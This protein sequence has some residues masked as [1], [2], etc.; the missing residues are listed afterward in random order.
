V[1]ARVA[2]RQITEVIHTIINRW[3]QSNTCQNLQERHFAVS[4]HAMKQIEYK[5]GSKYI[6]LPLRQQRS[7]ISIRLL[8]QQVST[9]DNHEQSGDANEDASSVGQTAHLRDAH[10][11][12]GGIVIRR[13][14]RVAAPIEGV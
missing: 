14:R 8:A 10:V 9:S 1:L 4:I 7:S 13:G 2:S 11:V 3:R 5:H 6:S 12:L